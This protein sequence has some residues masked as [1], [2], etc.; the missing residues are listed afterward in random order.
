[1]SASEPSSTNKLNLDVKAMER[2]VDEAAQLLK[3][4]SNR[5]RLI[6]LC[7]LSEGELS[8]G[9]LHKRVSLSQSALS[10]HLAVLR[11]DNLVSTRKESQT[12]HYSLQNDTA[13][14]V[15]E[16]LHELYC[17]TSNASRSKPRKQ[18]R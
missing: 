17:D 16:L 3:A 14:R 5:S 18:T 1:M 6:V 15:I 13:V 9:E 12:V 7:I 4:L 8:V 2:H 11:R 10:Q